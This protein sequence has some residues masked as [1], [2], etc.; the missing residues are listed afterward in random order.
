MV[1]VANIEFK[2]NQ[3]I[4]KKIS[5]QAAAMSTIDKMCILICKQKGKTVV[6]TYTNGH[7]IKSENF[8]QDFLT[9]A[10]DAISKGDSKKIYVRHMVPSSKLILLL[11]L[12]HKKGKTIFYEI[13]T[14]PYYGEQIK[15]AKNKIRTGTRLFIDS[16]FWPIIYKYITKLLVVKSRSNIRMYKKMQA[17][18]N[19]VDIKSIVTKRIDANIGNTIRLIGVGS[20]YKYHG[21]DRLIEGLANYSKTDSDIRVEFHIVGKSIEIDN[22]KKLAYNYGL[23][24]VFFHGLKTTNELN[25]MFDDYQIGVG[26]LSLFRRNAD[27][28]TTIKVIE[29][30]SRGITVLSSGKVP[31]IEGREQ[32][33]IK[34]PND[35]SAIN[36]K[37]ILDGLSKINYNDLKNL[38]SNAKK[39]FNWYNILK[40]VI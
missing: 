35:N 28:D 36:V 14:Y 37:S 26:C 21:Y 9:Y 19:G 4:S 22:L 29:Y 17:V 2:N 18:T 13:P 34:V 20:I 24:C 1:F 32:C 8:K 6:L 30:Y 12:A 11:K 27:I 16:V 25:A 39:Q 33:V 3:G 7:Y 40:K 38:S 5:A 31:L 10:K 15:N 23:D